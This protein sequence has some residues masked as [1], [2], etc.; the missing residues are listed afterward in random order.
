MFIESSEFEVPQK[1]SSISKIGI[2]SKVGKLVS[3]N[4]PEG[5]TI[6]TMFD[7]SNNIKCSVPNSRKFLCLAAVNSLPMFMINM[8]HFFIYSFL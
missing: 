2:I 7:I 8:R 6:P 3:Q 1:L 4:Y 5:S